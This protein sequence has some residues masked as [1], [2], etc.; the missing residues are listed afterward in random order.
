MYYR[1]LNYTIDWLLGGFVSGEQYDWILYL[2]GYVDSV[3]DGRVIRKVPNIW[4]TGSKRLP[5]VLSTKSG[6]WPIY[7]NCNQWFY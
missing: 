1:W 5:K 3:I 2:T 7:N 6:Q 4:V